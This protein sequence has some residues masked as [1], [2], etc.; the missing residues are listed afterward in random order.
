MNKVMEFLE[1]WLLPVA[2][3]LNNNRY[4]TALRDGFMVALPVIIF[5]SIFVVIANFPFLDRLLGE[6][7]YAAYQNAL[8]PAS[9]ATLSLMGLFVIVGIGYKLTEHYGGQ[10]IYGGVVAIASFLILTPQTVE[11]VTGA[12][13]TSSLG[14]QGL[15]LGI[16]TAIISAEL[17]R[18][19]VNKNWVIKMPA[20][21]PEAVSRSFSSLIPIGLTLTV[22]LL[23]RILFSYTPYETV[24]NFIYTVIQQPLTKLGSGFGATIVAVIL[25]QIFWFFGL[26]GQII[27]NTVFDPI[28]Y[29]LNDENFQA[30]QAGREL[31]N[32]ITKQFIDTFLVGM[33]G[34]GMTLAV[35]ILI[36]LIGRS[37]QVKELGKLG[38]PP[39]IFNV[40][41]PITFGLPIILNP[42][43][44]IPWILAPVVVTVITYFAMASGLVPKPAG[45]IVPWTT[46]IGISGF[47]ATGNA[48]QGAVLQIFNLL[49]VM[50]IWWPFLKIID[51]S[52]YEK[53]NKPSE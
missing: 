28:W 44:L 11:K 35:V 16:F 37:R 40:N 51:K 43:A 42:L 14:A 1:R 47:L 25:I 45:I 17:Y 9:A 38:G 12:I 50:A 20:G 46:P 49:V 7:A 13:P 24:Q 15:F 6:E 53:E 18:F 3:K 19:F 30:F 33:G 34:S 22:F 48:W 29:A 8:G 23:V 4:L 39:G 26:H 31:P 10:A 2:E 32:V 52:Y 5:G 21:V 41:E 36:F 27:V